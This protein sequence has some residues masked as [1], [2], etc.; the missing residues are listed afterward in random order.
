MLNMGVVRASV[1]VSDMGRAKK[2]YTDMLGLKVVRDEGDV[3][4]ELEA[5]EGSIMGLYVSQ[6]AGTAQ[7]TVATF[8]VT[9]FEA[10]MKDLRDRGVTF[11]DYDLPGLKTENGVAQLGGYKGGWFKDP[12]GNILA[13]VESSP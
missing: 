7:N 13:I 6:F 10:T 2:F 4:L 5:G 12:D 3:G 1:A 9:D 8:N 11:E